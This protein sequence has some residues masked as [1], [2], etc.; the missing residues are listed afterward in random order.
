MDT[1]FENELVIFNHTICIRIMPE[2][3]CSNCQRVFSQKGHLTQHLKR[4]NQC[5]KT[6]APEVIIEKKINKLISTQPTFIEVCSGCG[7]L[8]SGFIEAGFRPI[9]LNE[10]DKTFCETLRRNH[11]GV[12]VLNSD[13]QSIHLSDYLGMV[14]VLMGGVPCQAFSQAGE[15]KGLE[16]PRGK[17][18]LDFNRLVQECK[19][20]IL[21]VE[22]VK[23]LTTHNNGQ[24]LKGVLELFSNNGEYRMYH[25]ILNATNYE[26]PQKRERVIIIGVRSDIEKEYTY[27]TPN[28]KKV[29]LRDVLV[30]VPIS[31][32][33][34]YPEHKRKIMDMVPEGGC[35]INLPEDVQ[36]SYM[37]ASYMS[38]GGKRGIARRLSMNEPSLT[39]TTSPCQKQTERCHP[40]ETR[41]LNVRE[42][43]R[44]QTFPDTYTFA[45]S[46]NNQYKQIG[47]A[48]P[49]KLAQAIG[50][51]IKLFLGDLNTS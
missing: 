45:G 42:Y 49:V 14:D 16:D 24:T 26:V 27:P 17:L 21:L 22:N 31:A 23:G 11:P 43:A 7:G 9:L 34:K 28:S 25:K 19:P 8:S 1:R 30:N 40:L 46:M 51:S 4:K 6:D 12:N 5:K 18:I 50:S 29:I 47:N 36:R 35:W 38:G 33:A 13:M 44:I 10:L 39:L 15:R 20:K 2:H 41:P 48:V 3:R 32:G 37:G